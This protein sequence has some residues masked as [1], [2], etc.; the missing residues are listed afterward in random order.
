MPKLELRPLQA[1]L[2]EKVSEAWR[3]GH[4]RVMVCAPCGFGKTE[5]ATAILQTTRN[6]GK[7]GLFIADRKALVNQT[8]ARFDKYEL[9]HGIQMSD[10]WRFK[11][12]EAV[13][14]C[15]A[16]T[17]ARRR[18]PDSQL[19]VIDEAHVLLDVVRKKLDEK[20]RYA[21][22]L[23]ATPVTKGLGKHF[24]IVINAATTNQLIEA[25]LLVP[26]R[27]FSCTEPNMDGVKVVAGEWEEKEVSKRALQ[28]VGDVVAEY[29]KHGAGKKFVAFAASIDHAKELQRQ[30]IAA[31]INVATYTAE[32]NDDDRNEVVAEFGKPQSAIRGLVSVEALTRGFDVTDVEVLILAR[33]LRKAFAVHVQMLGRVMRAHPGKTHAM[34]F[35]HAGNCLRFW[36]DQSELFEYGVKALDDGK[37]KEKPK[38]TKSAE[39]EPV[40]CPDCR[41]IHAPAPSCPHCG[42]QYPRRQTVEHVPGTLKELIACGNGDI[43]RRQLWPQ[44]VSYVLEKDAGD[45][46][47]AQRRAQGIFKDLTGEFCRA[48]VETTTPVECSRDLR[49]KILANTIRWSRRQKKAQGRVGLA[50]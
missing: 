45:L 5:C 43:Q 30:F 11:P 33:P 34:V 7:R 47:K 19:M 29:M 39:K 1:S 18:W 31:G 13:Q 12:S 46:V 3:A 16:Q 42:H 23:S 24:D 10:H 20:D 17:L 40:K 21:I 14:I 35:D 37:K 27:I 4:K 22:G 38:A 41:A 28:V 15:S 6:N 26:L 50:A 36:K 25:G 2:L 48:R 32:D 8:S 9:P 44:I 49:N